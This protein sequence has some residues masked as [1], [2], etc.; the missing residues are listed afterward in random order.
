M[1]TRTSIDGKIDDY[2][3]DLGVQIE[4]AAADGILVINTSTGECYLAVRSRLPH[5]RQPGV[6]LHGSVPL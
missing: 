4:L 6:L 1:A 2:A 3:Y 5:D